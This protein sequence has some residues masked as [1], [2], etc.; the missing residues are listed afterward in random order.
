MID[1]A[2]I[3]K[4]LQRCARNWG[5]PDMVDHLL[6]ARRLASN[7]LYDLVGS[8]VVSDRL[9]DEAIERGLAEWREDS[10]KQPASRPDVSC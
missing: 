2:T 1:Q 3:L 7:L 10:A 5:E 9:C 8:M 4:E 6:G